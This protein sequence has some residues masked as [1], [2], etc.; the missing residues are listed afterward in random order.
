M[1]LNDISAELSQGSVQGPILYLLFTADISLP[2]AANTML[3]TFVE[4]TV[5]SSCRPAG[6]H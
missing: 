1:N 4:D 3:T 6:Y 2:T 5:V